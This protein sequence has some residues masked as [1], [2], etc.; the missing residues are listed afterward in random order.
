MMYESLLTVYG[1]AWS[2]LALYGLSHAAASSRKAGVFVILRWSM[3]QHR[4]LIEVRRRLLELGCR[5]RTRLPSRGAPAQ[6]HMTARILSAA[7]SFGAAL[8]TLADSALSSLSFHHS[9]LATPAHSSSFSMSKADVVASAC[10]P[11]LRAHLKALLGLE[12]SLRRLHILCPEME[13]AFLPRLKSDCL[14]INTIL[15]YRKTQ[16]AELGLRSGGNACTQLNPTGRTGY[17]IRSPATVPSPQGKLQG[18]VACHTFMFVSKCC[19][20]VAP[21]PLRAARARYTCSL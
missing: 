12:E 20:P 13:S 19:A 2:S 1:V 14:N 8:T 5:A 3:A 21:R 11:R 4:S 6:H 17:G 18:C 9:G 7:P 16:H 15:S 10:R